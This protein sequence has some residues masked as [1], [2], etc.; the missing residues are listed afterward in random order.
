MSNSRKKGIPF[1]P[2]TIA[3]RKASYTR[4]AREG[5]PPSAAFV[6]APPTPR[7]ARFIVTLAL[8]PGATLADARAYVDTEIR[9]ACGGYPPG[10]PMHNLDRASVRVRHYNQHKDT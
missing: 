10:D 4:N 3:K 5:G 1:A 9:A 8:P 7:R 2:A 6:H